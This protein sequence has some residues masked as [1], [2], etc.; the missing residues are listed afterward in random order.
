V[1]HLRVNNHLSATSCLGLIPIQSK[2]SEIAEKVYDDK[3]KT[4]TLW[5]VELSS[6]PSAKAS[7]VLVKF[8]R[9]RYVFIS[10]SYPQRIL[11]LG[12]PG[13]LEAAEQMLTSTLKWR[14]EFKPDRKDEFPEI[15]SKVGV[16]SGKDKDGRPVTYNF[17]GAQDPNEVFKDVD[18][19][20]R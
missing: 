18:Q 14:H 7:V 5:G 20:I 15:F 10:L 8:V 11:S 6:T 2:L 1:K 12:R 9:A 3:N 4:I 17:Y 16:I 13:D 19:F